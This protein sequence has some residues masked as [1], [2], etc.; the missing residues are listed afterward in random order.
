MNVL[1]THTDLDGVC[2][3]AIAKRYI[4]GNVKVIFSDPRYIADTLSQLDSG[5]EKV[6]ITDISLN[7]D[8]VD[9]TVKALKKIKSEILWVDHHEWRQEDIEAVSKLCKLHV[10]SS[11]SA[12]SLFYRLYMRNDS[13]SQEIAG[14]G[15]DADTNTNAMKNT[16]AY[17]LGIS[18]KGGK[19]YLLREFSHGN[20][21]PER[22]EEWRVMVQEQIKVAEN[23]ISEIDP[24][25]TVTGKRFAVIDMRGKTASGTYTAKLAAQKLDLDFIMVIYNCRSVSFYRG[26][27]DVDLLPLAIN[28][29]GGGHKFA[30]GANPHLT[31]MERLMCRVRKTY[32]TKE[33][34]Q[35]INDARKI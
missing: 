9:Q 1:I 12:A 35:I 24:L 8:R 14:I 15:D 34:R 18:Q 27:R 10:E 13:I 17:K 21:E 33:I 26:I 11:P 23:F 28:H 6:I 16:L 3:G 19:F 29:Y 4:G 31:L 5:A 20:F 22:L 2:S 25:T 30:C 7:H 32:M